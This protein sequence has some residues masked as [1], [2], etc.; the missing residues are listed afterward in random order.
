MFIR[1]A[2]QDDIPSLLALLLQVG[3]VHHRI[4]PDIFPDG[5]QKYDSAALQTLLEDP[6]RPIYVA[7]EEAQVQGYCFC[8]IK[9]L[10]IGD[11]RRLEFYIDDLCVDE[12]HRRKGVAQ[13]LYR[14]ALEQARLLR[15]HSLTLN[16]WYGNDGA[17]AFYKNMGMTPRNIMMECKL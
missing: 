9:D 11:V 8:V 10:Q 5:M 15:C 2:R 7:V 16:V 3:Q 1:L 4:R 6:S 12:N 17:M 13:A 14:H